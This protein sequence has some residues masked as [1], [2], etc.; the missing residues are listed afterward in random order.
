MRDPGRAQ[1]GPGRQPYSSHCFES[2]PPLVVSFLHA[3]RPGQRGCAWQQ[4]TKADS[5][6]SEIRSNTHIPAGYTPTRLYY[7]DGQTSSDRVDRYVG[8]DTDAP[9][10]RRG[11]VRRTTRAQTD[12]S[13]AF[14]SPSLRSISHP[15]Y[16]PTCTGT[17]TVSSRQHPSHPPSRL[18]F[19]SLLPLLE[20]ETKTS[21]VAATRRRPSKK[22]PFVP[23]TLQSPTY[24][25]VPPSQRTATPPV[26]FTL[27]SKAVENCK[28]L[29]Q[30]IAR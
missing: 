16:C 26:P 14:R 20:L 12:S 5:S 1:A 22:D 21:L 3:T 18:H 8:T 19:T 7:Q 15:R 13:I 9:G 24:H 27:V 6:C 25:A 4:Q 11:R 2:L 17:G 28:S 30:I 10:A 29:D 23:P